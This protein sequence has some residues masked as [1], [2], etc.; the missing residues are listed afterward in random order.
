MNGETK[1]ALNDLLDAVEDLTTMV[2]EIN[3]GATE[4][5]RHIRFFLQRADEAINEKDDLA[6]NHNVPV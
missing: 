2:E 4:Q 5:I 3:P 6:F 1:R